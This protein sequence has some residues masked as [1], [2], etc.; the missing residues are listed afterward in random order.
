[1]RLGG[2]A[3][4]ALLAFLVSKAVSAETSA[5]LAVEQG[6]TQGATI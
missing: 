2:L 3:A 4:S 5:T 6:N 1:M